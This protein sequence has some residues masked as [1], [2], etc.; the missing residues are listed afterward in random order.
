MSN[1]SLEDTLKSL[2][3]QLDAIKKRLDQIEACQCAAC[4]YRL[5]DLR[6]TE[7]AQDENNM[8]SCGG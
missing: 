1:P 4:R 2:Q 3:R 6:K 7:E 8:F 5:E